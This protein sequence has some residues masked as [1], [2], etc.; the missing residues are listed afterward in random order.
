MLSFRK[1]AA[2]G[3]VAG[4]TAI[5][6]LA[7]ADGIYQGLPQIGLGSYCQST[8]SGVTL[9]ASQGAYAIVPGSTQGTG[10]GICAQ[11]VPAGPTTFTGNEHFA[12]DVNALGAASNGAPPAT[13]LVTLSQ[14]GAGAYLD[15]TTVTSSTIPNNTPFYFI[16]GADSNPLGI[17]LPANPLD[18]QI[19]HVSCATATVG[20]L[21]VLPNVGQSIKPTPTPNVACVAGTGYAFRYVAANTTWYKY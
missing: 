9:P 15:L 11:T 17:T 5:A 16:D 12:V 14:L 6:S 3:L 1:A 2:V 19:Q 18:G 10:A 4:L 8:V 7:V 13:A 21:L 20:T